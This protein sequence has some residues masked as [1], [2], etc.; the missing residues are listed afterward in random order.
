MAEQVEHQFALF[1]QSEMRPRLPLG[2]LI[3]KERMEEAKALLAKGDYKS[4]AAT[5]RE[6]RYK[7]EA[8]EKTIKTR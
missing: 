6:A 4:C 5:L 7:L 3:S 2:K 1:N 8:F